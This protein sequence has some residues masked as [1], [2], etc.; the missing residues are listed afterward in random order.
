MEVESAKE[1][2]KAAEQGPSVP[3][4]SSSSQ[5]LREGSVATGHLFV[6]VIQSW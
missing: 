6:T 4:S 3:A 1:G 2:V 5:Q